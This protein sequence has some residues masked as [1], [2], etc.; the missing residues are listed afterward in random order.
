MRPLDMTRTQLAEAVYGGEGQ[1]LE[2]KK[3]VPNPVRMAKEVVA[4]ANTTGG[5]IVIG[6]EDSGIVTGVKDVA[7]EEFALLQA[8]KTCCRPPVP[9]DLERVSVSRKR[10]AI[11]VTVPDSAKKP[12]CVIDAATGQQTAYI[13]IDHM[14]VE[15]SLEAQQLMQL[16][17][18]QTDV[19]FTV[20]EKERKLLQ[21]VDRHGQINVRQFAEVAGVSRRVASRTL[22]L[23]TRARMLQHHSSLEEDYFTAGPEIR[24]QS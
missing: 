12:H 17:R 16:S 5:L 22:V 4:F 13:R 7:E 10:Q 18:D 3:R 15:A 14:S 8:L 23:L 6:V 2:F 20:R 24:Q 19:L 11:V 1:H 9:C 21:Y